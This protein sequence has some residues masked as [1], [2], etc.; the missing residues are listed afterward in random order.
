MVVLAPDSAKG[1]AWADRALARIR[2]EAEAIGVQHGEDAHRHDH[3]RTRRPRV[4]GL[5]VSVGAEREDRTR[6]P[7]HD[8]TTQEDH[9]GIVTAQR[10]LGD[11]LKRSG[12]GRLKSTISD[13]PG[14]WPVDLRGDQHHMGTTRMH[15]DPRKGVVDENC[16]VHGTENLF[17]ASSAV[18]PTGGTFNPTLTILALAVRL[19][20]HVKLLLQH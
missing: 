18:F 3:G 12:F 10:L 7:V 8:S 1:K 19:A 15:R 17:V 14:E 20:D 4:S 11:E 9:R 16:R 2:C 6:V 13:S 5:R